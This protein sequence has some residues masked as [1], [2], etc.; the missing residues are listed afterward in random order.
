MKKTI[1]YALL[2]L[3]P[4]LAFAQDK[5]ITFLGDSRALG[6]YLSEVCDPAYAEFALYG[7]GYKPVSGAVD[8]R[9]DSNPDDDMPILAD[10]AVGAVVNGGI[11][12]S[13]TGTW[14]ENIISHPC[15]PYESDITHVSLGGNDVF[16]VL[17]AMLTGRAA[18]MIRQNPSMILPWLWFAE[19][20][21]DLIAIRTRGIVKYILDKDPGNRVLMNDVA[22]ILMLGKIG[23][24]WWSTRY[25]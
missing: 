16:E 1:I 17:K 13:T 4:G 5:K 3:L 18:F 11:G 21:T 20:Q 7:C 19:V 2:M 15:V 10:N 25:V 8:P 23:D 12:G 14:I 24:T 9:D 22:P 6:L